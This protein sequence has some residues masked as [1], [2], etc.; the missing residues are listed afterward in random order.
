MS[1]VNNRVSQVE[2]ILSKVVNIQ[3]NLT[4]EVA[5][6]NHKIDKLTDLVA[7]Q[8]AIQ[9][10]ITHLKHRLEQVEKTRWWIATV[11]IG[12]V[13]TAILRDVLIQ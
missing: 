12:A 11:V 1:D 5:R 4:G 8:K 10:E 13:A 6:V 9:T 3:D 2:Q 7:E